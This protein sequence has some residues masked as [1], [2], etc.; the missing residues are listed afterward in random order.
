[1]TESKSL[2]LT[3]S[4]QVTVRPRKKNEGGSQWKVVERFGGK[5]VG[6]SGSKAGAQ[7]ATAR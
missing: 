1:M 4:K 7:A 5:L 3:V 2:M 6:E